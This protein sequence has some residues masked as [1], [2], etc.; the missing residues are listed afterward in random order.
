[1]LGRA[2]LRQAQQPRPFPRLS[3]RR[4]MR[5]VLSYPSPWGLVP[6]LGLRGIAG[7]K[8]RVRLLIS[9]S[10]VN[11]I[12]FRALIMVN[13]VFIIL[14]SR[15]RVLLSSCLFVFVFA[16][17][18]PD[19]APIGAVPAEPIFSGCIPSGKNIGRSGTGSRSESQKDNRPRIVET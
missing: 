10:L 16:L 3:P 13:S 18:G 17:G 14:S 11:R 19:G 1:L 4:K 15:L 6:R 2:M 5:R 7:P 8:P 9:S 12:S